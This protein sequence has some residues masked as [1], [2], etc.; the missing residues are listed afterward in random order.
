M[1]MLYVVDSY[2]LGIVSGSVLKLCNVIKVVTLFHFKV[3]FVLLSYDLWETP[4]IE[5]VC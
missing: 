1:R 2:L 5:R 3:R 4:P